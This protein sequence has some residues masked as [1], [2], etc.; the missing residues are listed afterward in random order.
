MT[1]SDY[2]AL[3]ETA[4]AGIWYRAK[5]TANPK[6]YILNMQKMNGRKANIRAYN[7]AVD[8]AK[9]WARA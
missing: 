1:S 4:K 6:G 5:T 2:N 8:I 7:E 9:A 3:V